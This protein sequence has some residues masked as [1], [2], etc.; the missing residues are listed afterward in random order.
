MNIDRKLMQI[1]QTLEY[2]K[3]DSKDNMWK[4][5]PVMGREI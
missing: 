5:A 2:K 4:P 3:V 1:D